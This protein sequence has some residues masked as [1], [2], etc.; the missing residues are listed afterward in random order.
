MKVK[1]EKIDDNTVREVKTVDRVQVINVE[2]TRAQLRNYQSQ[3]AEL[4][5][6]IDK[7]Q[8]IIDTAEKA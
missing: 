8:S 1:F 7:A 6:L 4:D 2:M 3:R 5:V